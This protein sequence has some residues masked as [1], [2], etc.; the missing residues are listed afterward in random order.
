MSVLDG[1]V[2]QML[3]HSLL[4][5]SV[6][7]IEVGPLPASYISS[8]PPKKQLSQARNFKPNYTLLRQEG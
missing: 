7:V 1:L 2:L 6:S 5:D 8:L 3:L 4:S